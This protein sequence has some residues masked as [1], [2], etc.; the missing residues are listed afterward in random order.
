MA[1]LL[2]II[3][4]VFAL[5]TLSLLIWCPHALANERRVQGSRFKLR[6]QDNWR[7]RGFRLNSS[8]LDPPAP[9]FP[10]KMW[11]RVAS[12]DYDDSAWISVRVPHDF[13]ISQLLNGTFNENEPSAGGTGDHGY[14][15]VGV[16]WYRCQFAIP[17]HA[18][19]LAKAAPGLLEFGGV[20]RD[21]TV[22]LNGVR[23]GN[24]SSGYT[25]FHLDIPMGL[26]RDDRNV[27]VVRADAT[28]SEGWFY[29]GG[30][31]YRDV[32]IT[33]FGQE[34]RIKPW[35]VRILS[36]VDGN[37]IQQGTHGERTAPVTINVET[38]ID[39]GKG[40]VT[41]K[42]LSEAS[43]QLLTTIFEW[44]KG[45]P[46]N[47]GKEIAKKLSPVAVVN[48]TS[49]VVAR[50]TISL[51]SRRLWDIAGPSPP[52]LYVGV[53]SLLRGGNNTV[54][55]S[56]STRFGPRLIEFFG[57]SGMFLNGRHVKIKGMASHM[58]FAG[59]GQAVPKRIQYFKILTLLAMGANAW[60]CAHNPPNEAFLDAADELGFL[61]LDENRHFG[62][63]P[64][65]WILPNGPNGAAW[66]AENF[67]DWQSM[68]KRDRN[69]PSIFAWSLCN[70]PECLLENVTESLRAGRMY[71][72]AAEQLDPSRPVTGAMNSDWGQGLG[73][74]LGI[75]GFNYNDG[76]YEAFHNA[77]PTTPV[78]ATETT[79]GN[80]DRGEYGLDPGYVSSFDENQEGW[81]K[82]VSVPYLIGGFAWTA[83]DYKG[84]ATWPSINSHFGTLDIA[85]F[86]KDRFY[87]YK[88]KW[89]V[90]QPVLH[91]F[92]ALS[93]ADAKTVAP[94]VMAF[95]NAEAVELY[96][97]DAETGA[98]L[99]RLGRSNVQDCVAAGWDGTSGGVA[100]QGLRSG[101]KLF[102]VAL[103]NGS[104]ILTNV[105][106]GLPGPPVS[107]KLS[108]EMD[109]GALLPDGE[110]VALAKVEVVDADGIRVRDASVLVQF[111]V[112]GPATIIGVGNGDPHCHEADKGASRS[113]FHGLARV[114]VQH[115]EDSGEYVE[116]RAT[117]SGLLAGA[118]KMRVGEA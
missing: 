110:D 59:V 114:I 86:P 55:D 109:Q 34:T 106:V 112:S 72:D 92:G 30:G 83:F 27:L 97:K 36:D 54:I 23:L 44:R 118:L 1:R 96:I 50:Q 90:T 35:G 104:R 77:H 102:A 4:T 75:Q 11:D 103:G 101:E 82:D 74:T 76:Q 32:G 91:V 115:R 45:A 47:L 80:E 12:L 26:I 48:A 46:G 43:L 84:E 41:E 117:S 67:E 17:K 19:A 63:Q 33:F 73:A 13:V 64:A 58:G 39:I 31:I 71:V 3:K 7:F 87:W 24:H 61:V 10:H 88:A 2:T 100:F 70:E 85:G 28:K 105:S 49:P 116:L 29:E 111:E 15:P 107:L 42:V 21:S 95:T 9:D 5:N 18:S 20:F 25:S 40:F 66:D 51:G 65:S 57:A 38:R 14:L 6:L 16:G 53:S 78:L 81:V 62:H 98:I 68:I 94:R 108:W 22:W 89:V 60:R 79:N 99:R 69:H 113:T 93:A 37:K 52:A 8:S 56:F